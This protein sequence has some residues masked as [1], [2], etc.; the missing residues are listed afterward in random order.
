M[1]L[2]TSLVINLDGNLSSRA[3]QFLGGLQRLGSGGSRSM[4]I[5]QRSAHAAGQGLD[6]LG[7]RY[8][9]LLTGAAGI[10][11]ARQVMALEERFVRLG[12]TVG[13]SNKEMAGLKKEIFETAKAPDIRVDPGEII[14]AI[15]DITE[16]SGNLKFARDNI[17]NIGLAIQATGAQGKDIGAVMAEF[18]KMGIVDPKQVM[19]AMDILNV[20][21]KEGAFT[22]QNLAS[23]GPRVVTAYTSMGRGGVTAIREMGAAL[24]I[25][26]M[27]TGSSEQ[28]ATAF[29]AVMR[30]LSDAKKVKDLQKG[31]IQVFDPNALKEGKETL[32]PIN[33]LMVEIVKKTG[34]KKTLLS[35]VFDAEAI[36]AFNTAAAEFQRTGKIETLE[37]F[38]RV[39]AD[40]TTTTRD[41]AR[42]A[43]TANAALQNLLTVWKELPITSWPV[44]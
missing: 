32:R 4:Q 1:A 8:T 23:L 17:R 43:Q 41:S 20:Q 26:R 7:N 33:E 40:G 44:R 9:A 42:A 18:E 22:L 5:L 29:E 21:G 15:E 13:R 19:E 25:I 10:G 36:R 35:E 37:K 31:G 24:Q 12:I 28:A 3:N 27:G 11:A 39:Q 34:G 38:Y 30:T 16:K 14:G 2:K 6:R